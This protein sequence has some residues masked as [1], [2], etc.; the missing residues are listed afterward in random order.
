MEVYKTG[1]EKSIERILKTPIGSRVMLPEYGSN[2]FEIIDKRLDDSTKLDVVRYV[3][4]AIERWEPR[5]SFVECQA[6]AEDIN[7]ETKMIL[8]LTVNEKSTN[9]IKQIEVVI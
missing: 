9:E 8:D 4:E 7:G 2:L 1:V 5:V 6:S 3:Y